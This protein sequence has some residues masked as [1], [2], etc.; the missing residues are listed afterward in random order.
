MQTMN[1]KQFLITICLFG[2]VLMIISCL[3]VGVLIYAMQKNR[4]TLPDIQTEYI[5]VYVP[6][7]ENDEP[8]SLK[9][10]AESTGWTLKEHQGRIGIFDTTG[11]LIQ[12]IDTYVKTL[13]KADQS[14]LGEGIYADTEQELRSLIEDY[15]D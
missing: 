11:T 9:P 13:P 1:K 2:S 10:D 5:Y 8:P 14:M 7:E 15:S 3:A 12:V 6:K 4:S